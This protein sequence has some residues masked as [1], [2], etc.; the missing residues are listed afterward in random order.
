[1]K[2]RTFLGLEL[3]QNCVIE[4]MFPKTYVSKEDKSYLLHQCPS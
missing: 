3:E 1:M 4:N 2:G